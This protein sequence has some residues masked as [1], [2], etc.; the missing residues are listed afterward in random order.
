SSAEKRRR[1]SR[2]RPRRDGRSLGGV[3][4]LRSRAGFISELRT[5]PGAVAREREARAGPAR[6]VGRAFPL[7]CLLSLAPAGASQAARLSRIHSP[8]RRERLSLTASIGMYGIGGL[9]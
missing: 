6:M 3:G 1:D 2:R 4:S 5:R 9:C 7:V 8:D